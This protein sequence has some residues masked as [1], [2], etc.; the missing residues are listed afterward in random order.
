MG[1]TTGR[2]ET[3]KAFVDIEEI[4]DGTVIVTLR[5]PKHHGQWAKIKVHGGGNL[6]FRATKAVYVDGDGD[7]DCYMEAHGMSDEKAFAKGTWS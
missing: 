1:D 6:F 2:C 4:K 3:V 5:H 7:A